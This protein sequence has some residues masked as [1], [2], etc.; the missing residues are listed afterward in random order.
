MARS[1]TSTVRI[2]QSI[3][4]RELGAQGY[5]DVEW[6]TSY[7]QAVTFDDVGPV[8]RGMLLYGQSVDP[9]SPHYADQ[10]PVYSQKQWPTL[11]FSVGKNSRRSELSDH[12]FV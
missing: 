8:A 2:T 1:A 7:V 5:R 11:P 12:F 9:A 4:A 3:C 6:G 10:L